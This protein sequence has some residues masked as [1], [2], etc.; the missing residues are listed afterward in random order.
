MRVA[1]TRRHT[2]QIRCELVISLIQDRQPAGLFGDILIVA[3]DFSR[4]FVIL[5]EWVGGFG[6]KSAP[7]Q[8]S[9]W[10]RCQEST[11]TIMC[12]NRNK[13]K[14][15]SSGVKSIFSI[16][17]RRS[18]RYRQRRNIGP[19]P[20][21]GYNLAR[22]SG[23]ISLQFLRTRWT[24]PCSP[25]F[26]RRCSSSWVLS[27]AAV[28]T[29]DCG[30]N[31]LKLQEIYQLR[32][33]SCARTVHGTQQHSELLFCLFTKSQFRQTHWYCRKLVCTSC[34]THGKLWALPLKTWMMVC[35]WPSGID[36]A[37]K[38]QR[39]IC[40]RRPKSTVK[41]RTMTTVGFFRLASEQKICRQP[42]SH[43]C[44]YLVRQLW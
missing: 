31:S 6:R 18:Y 2:E 11:Y 26:A 12:T 25:S 15:T 14:Y 3:L 4:V 13:R 43:T 9:L 21:G 7:A 36:T 30:S 22:A 16:V 19:R 41:I 27:F 28:H 33:L 35:V 5:V 32:K 8:E 44:I 37:G 38:G 39:Q 20:E 1:E 42:C 24:A 40:G 17:F 23:Y 10:R 34:P 29:A